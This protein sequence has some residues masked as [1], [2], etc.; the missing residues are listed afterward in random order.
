MP[1]SKDQTLDVPEVASFWTSGHEQPEEW[2]KEEHQSREI[3]Q[4]VYDYTP[5]VHLFSGE[6]FWPCDIAEHLVHTSPYQNYTLIRNMEND[7]TLQN[8]DE[9]N[10]YGQHTYLQSEDNVEERPDWLGGSRNIPS[11]PE[12]SPVE[13]PGGLLRNSFLKQGPENGPKRWNEFDPMSSTA[14]K[15]SGRLQHLGGH[16]SAPAILIVVPK[17]DG[18]VD[19]FW[20]YFYSYNLGNKVFNIRFG[21]HVGDWEHSMVRFR[22]GTP[23]AVYISEHGAGEAYAYHAVEK[24][25]KR[26]VIYSATGT[27]AIYATPGV[28]PYI[29]PWGLLHD[30]TDRGPLWDPNL[31]HHAYVYNYTSR[32]LKSSAQTPH[33]PVHWFNFGGHWGDKI[34]PMSDSRQY[35]FWGQYHYVSGPFGPRFKH[36]GRKKVCQLRGAQ[37]VIKHWLGDGEHDGAKKLP[38]V[39]TEDL[40]G[41]GEVE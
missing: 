30:Q 1:L 22:N 32:H 12:D 37:C 15:P 7:R 31:N 3:P 2:S 20:F 33:A 38:G 29:L 25:G 14:G 9:L 21:N 23:E 8:L 36:L 5:Y 18:V 6:Q 16:S 17:D 35:R 41:P 19:A 27:H 26:P 10:T 11:S 34:Y 13:T 28:H 39:E 4:Y 40:K 24:I